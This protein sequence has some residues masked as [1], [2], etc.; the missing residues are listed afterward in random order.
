MLKKESE[1]LHLFAKEPWKSYTFTEVKKLSKKKSRSYIEQVIKKF[2]D[3]EI[4]KKENVGKLPVYSL[5]ISSVLARNFGGFV[6][7]YYGWKK[8][9]ISYDD[10]QKIMKIIPYRSYVFIVTGSYAR[11]RQTE[12]SDIDVVILIEDSS[13]PSRVYAE[14]SHYCELNM[15]PIHLYVF[16]YNEFIEM[17]CNNEINYGK[18]IAKNSLILTGGEIYIKLMGEAIYNGFNDKRLA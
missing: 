1:L 18:E 5:N 16:R 9:H 10:L 6:L 8:K 2:V 12:G 17:L 4:L 7:E 3:G 14:L 13:E 15:P 11:G